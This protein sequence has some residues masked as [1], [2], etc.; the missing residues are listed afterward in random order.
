M[1]NLRIDPEPAILVVFVIGKVALKPFHMRSAFKGQ[2]VGGDADE[3]EAV[4]RD[5]RTKA[6]TDCIANFSFFRLN[7]DVR[8]AFPC[9]CRLLP[10]AGSALGF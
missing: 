7:F 6:A 1:R 9:L 10:F 4:M 5:V 8:F 2:H 3:E